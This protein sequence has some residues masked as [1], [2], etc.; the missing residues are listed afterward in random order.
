M[1]LRSRGQAQRSAACNAGDNG[2]Q[3]PLCKCPSG[4][5]LLHHPTTEAVLAALGR[6]RWDWELLGQKKL[7]RT[8]N[9][10]ACLSIYLLYLLKYNNTIR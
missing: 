5:W 6:D 2:S 4:R 9:R 8:G 1:P 3:L 10:S 7:Q